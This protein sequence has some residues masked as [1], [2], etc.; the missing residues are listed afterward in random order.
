LREGGHA[1]ASGRPLRIRAGCLVGTSVEIPHEAKT[2][3][4]KSILRRLASGMGV[5]AAREAV[6]DG[7]K[8][9][10]LASERGWLRGWSGIWGG[11]EPSGLGY[12]WG[13]TTQ[14]SR[15][16]RVTHVAQP[17]LLA[18]LGSHTTERARASSACTFGSEQSKVSHHFGIVQARPHWPTTPQDLLGPEVV[19]TR[20]AP[21]PGYEVGDMRI[22]GR[23]PGACSASR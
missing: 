13:R 5:K 19:D 7:A 22:P 2:G 17:Q 4:G 21:L 20:Q 16:E 12:G 15:A 23:Y 18:R 8:R 10:H 6:P 1:V 14:R 9:E 3:A 11:C